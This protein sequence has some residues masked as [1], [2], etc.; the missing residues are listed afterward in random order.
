MAKEIL[1]AIYNAEEECKAREAEAEKAAE[2]KID[3]AKKQAEELIKNAQAEAE[4]NS[5]A[6]IESIKAEAEAIY[7]KAQN[8]A[9]SKSSLISSTAEKNRADVIKQ[10]V[11]ALLH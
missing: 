11:E 7:N 10:S 3:A 4:K 2:E 6:R 9:D 5:E 1:D 8:A